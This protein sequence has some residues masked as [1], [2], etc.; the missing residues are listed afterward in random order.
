MM[1]AIIVSS[2]GMLFA[3]C[4]N[5]GAANASVQDDLDQAVT[6]IERFQA[7]PEKAIPDSVL[8]NA[9]GLAILTVT[10]AGF[11][12]GRGGIGIVV[13]RTG[14]GWSGPSAIGT[15]G[16]GVGFQ[17]GVEITEFVIVLNTQ[18]AVDAFAKESNVTLGANLSAAVG[19]VGRTAEANVALQA[20]MYTYSI[21]QG[22]FAGVSLEGAV[23]ATRDEANAEYYGKPVNAKDILAGKVR[24]P[25]GARK[26]LEVLSKY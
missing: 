26:L 11:I 13:A 23:I 14:N 18:E 6:I 22:L 8:R 25:A 19:P 10:K 21:S 7:I 5:I 15:G 1:R 20:A 17:A 2:L 24:P 3:A 16:L 4:L 9:K 12:V